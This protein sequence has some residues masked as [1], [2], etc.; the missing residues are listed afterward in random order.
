VIQRQH[1]SYT[2]KV[3]GT[4]DCILTLPSTHLSN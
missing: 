4:M 2:L 3:Q 1:Y